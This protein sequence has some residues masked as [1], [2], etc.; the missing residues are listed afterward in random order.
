MLEEITSVIHSED[1]DTSNHL[2]VP[3]ARRLVPE[4]ML[5]LA[6]RVSPF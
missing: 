1:S 3:V 4:F 5:K 6:G 2:V